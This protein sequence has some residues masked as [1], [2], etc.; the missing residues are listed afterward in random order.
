MSTTHWNAA[1]W[2]FLNS[3]YLVFK[4]IVT[5]SPVS[6]FSISQPSDGHRG[7][8]QCCEQVPSCPPLLGPWV[9]VRTITHVWTVALRASSVPSLLGSSLG[10]SDSQLLWSCLIL[11]LGCGGSCHWTWPKPAL[12]QIILPAWGDLTTVSFINALDLVA[13]FLCPQVHLL[14]V[15]DLYDFIAV[16]C[17]C[18]QPSGQC[19]Q[20]FQKVICSFFRYRW[21]S[22]LFCISFQVYS[23]V[24]RH[25]HNLYSDPPD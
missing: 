16:T 5:S 18:G 11:Q 13:C 24:A 9:Y 22:T 12:F 1:G 7:H 2:L 8:S 4:L 3:N 15:L 14:W 21:Y 25:L 6:L 10:S 17:C 23:I 19:C 20:L